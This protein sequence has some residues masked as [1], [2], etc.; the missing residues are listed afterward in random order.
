MADFGLSK[1]INDALNLQSVVIGVIPYLDPKR[2]N[3]GKGKVVGQSLAAGE[4]V[5]AGQLIN[6]Q[7]N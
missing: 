6:I 7:L 4:P 5:A 2:L 3:K 1:K